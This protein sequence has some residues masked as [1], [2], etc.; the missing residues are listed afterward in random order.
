MDSIN[1]LDP[2]YGNP[3]DGTG[4][5]VSNQIK[6]KKESR[7]NIE[8]VGRQFRQLSREGVTE[9]VANQMIDMSAEEVE[10]K[11]EAISNQIDEVKQEIVDMAVAAPTEEPEKVLEA[12]KEKSDYAKRL[13]ER[14]VALETLDADK[15][16]STLKPIAFHSAKPLKI[17]P[18]N[19]SV[20]SENVK[21]AEFVEAA[22][23]EEKAFEGDITAETFEQAAPA[24]EEKV[25]S[26]PI[27]DTEG[28]MPEAADMNG[29][30][31]SFSEPEQ[32]EEENVMDLEK[33]ELTE[34]DISNE[35]YGFIQA[36]AKEQ[37]KD[38]LVD[39]DSMVKSEEEKEEVVI[40]DGEEIVV[41]ETVAWEPTAVEEEK[42]ENVREVPEIAPEREE[43]IV[44]IMEME[45][46]VEK[47]EIEEE[48]EDL[49]FDYSDVTEK[50]IESTNSI[51]ILEEMRKA[52][53]KKLKEKREAEE[54]AAKEEKALVVSREEA[55]KLRKRAEEA[56][57]AVQAK[58][59]EFQ[60]Y[61]DS[62]DEEIEEANKR[63][64]KAA[65]DK[66]ETDE[67]IAKYQAS[68]SANTDI[69]K[70]LESMMTADAEEEKSTKKGK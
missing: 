12:I 70:E 19:Y 55:S 3:T 67:E 2:S 59:Q 6:F 41:P 17:K 61:I 54:K 25:V 26:E 39:M 47:E 24:E 22:P 68:I 66:A 1:V 4:S 23:Q 10:K 31:E 14:I 62:Y 8:R 46:S 36:Q 40:P 33:K 38:P 49:S 64:E 48:K 43:A 37:E 11:E 63:R 44:P 52:K 42:E 35:I 18:G 15:F 20:V 7:N 58:M 9:Q 32:S 29:V 27:V 13:E 65:S 50:D 69:E 28:F 16:V 34:E 60:K 56:E 53:E 21:K 45:D 5:L 51:A 30:S 57:K